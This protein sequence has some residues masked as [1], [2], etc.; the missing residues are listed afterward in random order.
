M[1]PKHRTTLEQWRIVQAVVDYGGYAKAGEI[2]HRSPSSL[3]HAVAKLQQQLGV[4]I[5]EVNGRK[6]Q[7]TAAGEV[8]LRRSRQL[9][10]DAHQLETLA[11]NLEMGWEPEVVITVEAI[12][13]RSCLLQALKEFYPDSRGTRVKIKETVITGAQEAVLEGTADLAITGQLPKG[14]LGE[15]LGTVALIAV[16]HRSHPLCQI[17]RPISSED[18]SSELQIVIRDS[19]K[20]PQETIGWLKAEQRWTVDNFE[21]A[22]DLL[23][24]GLG[25]CWVPLHKAQALLDSGELQRLNLRDG[26]IKKIPVYLV[27]PRPDQL[28]PCGREL[29]MQL[30]DLESDEGSWYAPIMDV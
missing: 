2:L 14:F 10:D 11:E 9:T 27:V 5:L 25:F 3:N 8:L 17:E 29:L 21:T 13:P 26:G 12:F 23:S 6:A 30:R 20:H 24:T 4:A 15:S 7:L 19:G 22:L 16:A 1:Q 18:L 28:G